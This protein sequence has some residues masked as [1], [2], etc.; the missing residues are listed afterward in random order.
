MTRLSEINEFGKPRVELL[1]DLDIGN[2]IKGFCVAKIEPKMA[3]LIGGL[4][5]K[6]LIPA[7]TLAF[8]A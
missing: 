4:R 6:T 2:M 8:N 3:I 7:P 1:E 5:Q